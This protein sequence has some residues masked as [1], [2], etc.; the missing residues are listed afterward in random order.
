MGYVDGTVIPV[1]QDRLEDYR[2][3][4]DLAALGNGIGRFSVAAS[5][6]PQGCACW[7]PEAST[8]N[9]ILK[10]RLLN[11]VFKEVTLRFA[12]A[13]ADGALRLSVERPRGRRTRSSNMRQRRASR[14]GPLPRHP[15]L[16]L[17]AAREAAV[18]GVDG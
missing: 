7:Q 5:P 2:K 17:S 1:P 4:A 16:P 15:S 10:L 18:E 8:F 11:P 6:S 3:Q 14:P 12:Q 9:N 13:A